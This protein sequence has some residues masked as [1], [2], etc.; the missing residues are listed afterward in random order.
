MLIADSPAFA[1]H[2]VAVW[3]MADGDPAVLPTRWRLGPH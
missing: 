3:A 2:A 1:V